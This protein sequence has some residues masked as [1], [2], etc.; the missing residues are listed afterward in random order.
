[1]RTPRAQAPWLL[2]HSLSCGLVKI[3]VTRPTDPDH[4][5][6][7]FIEDPVVSQVR[8]VD[9]LCLLPFGCC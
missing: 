1:L 6:Q 4:I 9:T 7:P 2:F 8:A 5:R 3:A